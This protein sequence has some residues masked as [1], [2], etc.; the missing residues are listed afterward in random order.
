MSNT[1]SLAS[2]SNSDL[3]QVLFSSG[4]QASDHP[5]PEQVRT[6][7][8]ACLCACDGDRSICAALV[9]QE[10]GDHPESYAARMRWALSTVSAAYAAAA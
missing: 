5:S 6:A 10:A 3:A 9:A 2:M 1:L 4:L 7:I 8:Y